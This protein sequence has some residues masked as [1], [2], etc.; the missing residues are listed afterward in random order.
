[1]AI[2]NTALQIEIDSNPALTGA[3]VGVI[4]QRLNAEGS[5]LVESWRVSSQS[6]PVAKEDFLNVLTMLEAAALQDLIDSTTTEGKAL[7]FK[8]AQ[9]DSI[10]MS[11]A[12]NRWFIS[13][14]QRLTV[15]T[16]T[17]ADALLRLGE[18][19]ASRAYELWGEAVTLEQIEAVMGV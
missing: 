12:G 16:Q 18:V 7:K 5:A 1:M 11:H 15:L 19:K 3:G 8:L 2:D 13:E 10:D 17:T 9:S 14:L 4:F 6:K